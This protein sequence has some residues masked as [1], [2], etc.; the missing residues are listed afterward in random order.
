MRILHTADW[1]FGKT[2]EG[3]DRLP[4]Q[5]KFVEELCAICDQE[6][7][8]LVLVAGDVYQ[9]ANPSAMAEELFYY[10][11]DRL[12]ANGKRGVVVISGNHDNPDRLAAASPLAHRHGIV[13]IG[14]PHEDIV[15]N[16]NQR[17]DRVNIKQAGPSWLELQIP[18]VDH[19]AVLAALPYPSEAR[20]RQLLTEST[21]DTDI[22][23][24]Y[25]A[26]IAYIFKNLS[27]NYR[28][29]S[30]NLA[31]SH[32]YVQGGEMSD[33]EHQIQVGGAYSV[34]PQFFPQTA[35]YVALGHLHRPQTVTSSPVPA[36]YSGSP[37]AY[38]FSEHN[39]KK[40]VVL[41]DVEPGKPAQIKE[42]PISS[43]KPLVKWTATEGIQQIQTWVQ[44]GKDADGW[45]DLA[46]HIDRPLGMDD[47]QL[48]RNLHK[49][50]I[51]IWPI[52]PEMQN[53]LSETELR[54]LSDEQMFVRFYEREK[55]ASPDPE[56]INLFLELTSVSDSSEEES[57]TSESEEMLG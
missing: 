52:L 26:Q 53:S 38:S 10:S 28:Q 2:L 21:E 16:P 30:V 45:I 37:L 41:L 17:P 56:L 15:W 23:K 29:D 9:T 8:D 43:G 31:M 7:V 39:H 51:N 50:I 55:G 1:H 44:E 35:Q 14:R 57:G 49:G 27:S 47:I 18:G 34:H 24:E 22:R 11:M 48:L 6:Q 36:R 3:R 25:N 33:S 4:E 46:V 40:S 13:L 54:N 5:E 42:I 19:S 32:M 12:A 20:L